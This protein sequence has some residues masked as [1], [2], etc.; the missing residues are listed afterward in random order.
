MISSNLL[1]IVIVNWNSGGQLLDVIDSIVLHHS[2]LLVTVIIIDNASS[3]DSLNQIIN[4]KNLPFN[5]QIIRNV[6]NK[7]FGAACNQGA[8]LV[9]SEYLLFLNPDTKLFEQSLSIPIAY[10]Q[11]PENGDVGIV[12]IQLLDEK[13]RIGRSCARFPT[14]K[15][16][17]AHALGISR[18]PS[19]S[20]LNVL[21]TEWSHDETQVVDHVIGAF[22]LIRRNIFK[23]LGGF[24]ERFFVYLED[25]DL[26]LRVRRAGYLCVYLAEAQ[27]YHIGGGTS[28]QVK[29]R[30]LFYSL[31]SRLL[32]GFKH[33]S[34]LDAWCLLFVTLAIE[35]WTRL[36]LALFKTSWRD[37]QHTLKAYG[38]LLQSLSKAKS[39]WR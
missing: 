21:M 7:G 18:L 9:T 2:E 15:I 20:Y 4:L 10:M 33:F 1:S 5:L 8:A 35:P 37:A 30:R 19:L 32:Y 34:S 22:F 25:L 38:L 17:S 27:A 13:N 36:A 12:G 31:H 39:F 23:S 3:D 26:S 24:D 11:D 16:F 29:A 28:R 14:L 6:D